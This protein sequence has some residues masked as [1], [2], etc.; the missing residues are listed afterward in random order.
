MLA[1]LILFI[2]EQGYTVTLGEGFDDDGVGHAKGSSHYIRLGQDLNVFLCGKWLDKGNE[3]EKAHG[4][5]HDKWDELGGAKRI[6][7]DLN[8]YSIEYRGRW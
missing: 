3:M 2:Y 8:H 7:N 4:L 5:I 1:K 6:K